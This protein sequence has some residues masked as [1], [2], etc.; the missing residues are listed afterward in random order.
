[1]LQYI[2][3]YIVHESRTKMHGI[4]FSEEPEVEF[5]K[6]SKFCLDTLKM[7][8]TKNGSEYMYKTIYII[9]YS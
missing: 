2:L 3:K 5:F 9:F 8:Y 7:V 1:M 6:E 4:M